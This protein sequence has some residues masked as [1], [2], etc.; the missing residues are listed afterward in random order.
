MWREIVG[1]NFEKKR[2]Y[3]R[4]ITGENFGKRENR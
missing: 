4:K 1:K 2:R 3:G